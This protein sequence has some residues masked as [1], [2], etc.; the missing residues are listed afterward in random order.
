MKRT[1][2]LILYLYLISLAAVQAAKVDTVHIYSTSMD[3]PIPAVVVLPDNYSEQN[4]YPVVYLL[5]GHSGDHKSWING[6]PEL[7]THVDRYNVIIVCPNGE[8]SWYWD[9]PIAPSS[10]YE[11]FV[12]QELT[13]WI[14][15]NYSTISNNKGRAITGLSMGGHG[16]MFLGIRH[17]NVFGACGSMSG[18][19]DIRPFPNNWNMSE[20]LGP[21]AE[22]P[23]HWESHTVINQLYLINP[24]SARIIFDCGTSDFFYD[25][26]VRLHEKMK[27]LNIPHD[28]TSR[29][30]DHDMNY[31]RNS[32]RYQMVFF[33]AF[34]KE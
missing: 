26:N 7:T 31:W 34:F 32:L 23:M 19:V 13:Q 28:F 6:N 17:Q 16:A 33:D 12:S 30:G 4:H 14:D 9:S 10:R 22:Y 15:K 1:I 8:N 25:V 20:S 3:K 18:G 11:T 29:P 2:T 27:Y 5:H 24:H 21:Q